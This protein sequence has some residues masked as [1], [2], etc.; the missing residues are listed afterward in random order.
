M[1]MNTKTYSELISISSFEE[2]FEYLRLKGSVGKDTFGYDRYLNQ[3]LY[4]S[5]E[6]KKTRNRI[7]ARDLGCDLGIFDRPI[8]KPNQLLIHHLNPISIE[9]V[10]NHDP[11]IFDP[12]NLITVSHST[13]NAIH[14]GDLSLLPPSI[15]NER[16]AGDTKLW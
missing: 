5:P 14:Y 8:S 7:I 16:K 1:R 10:I 15:P 4:N 6:W 9:Q 13:H 2:R 3:I 11:I 12:N